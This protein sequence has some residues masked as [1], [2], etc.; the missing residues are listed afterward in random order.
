MSSRRDPSEPS[1]AA[2]ARRSRTYLPGACEGASSDPVPGSL[3]HLEQIISRLV[4]AEM[5]TD[6]MA[7]RGRDAERTWAQLTA[8]PLYEAMTVWVM[9]ARP[10]QALERVD[11]MVRTAIASAHKVRDG[12]WSPGRLAAVVGKVGRRA[13]RCP[14]HRHLGQEI[15]LVSY[16]ELGL[17][18]PDD[19]LALRPARLSLGPA[20]LADLRSGLGQHAYLVTPFAA[21]LLERAV[22]LAVDHLD[23]VRERSASAGRKEALS[24]MALF[25]AARPTRRALKSNRITQVYRD[26]AHPTSVALAH[27]LLGTDHRPE[28]SLLWR[29]LSALAGSEAPAEVVADWRAELP[30]L[31][32]AVLALSERRRRRFRERCRRGEDLRYAFELAMTIE[33]DHPSLARNRPFASDGLS[34]AHR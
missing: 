32:P 8:T 30:A 5:P 14:V 26:L 21:R 28:A 20:V 3:D 6:L 15:Q 12:R 4:P 11:T 19:S 17:D 34:V 18:L 29:C 27:L 33:A 13:E 7:R 24:G 9:A 1:L 31:S 16:D 10:D 22:D 2:G 23:A 25:A